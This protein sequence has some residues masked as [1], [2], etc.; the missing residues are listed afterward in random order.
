MVEGGSGLSN[1][2]LLFAVGQ[3]VLSMRLILDKCFHKRQQPLYPEAWRCQDL[4]PTTA[5]LGKEATKWKSAG[6]VHKTEKV[7]L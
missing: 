2:E 7:L 5:A 3:A 1:V 4:P 6:Q